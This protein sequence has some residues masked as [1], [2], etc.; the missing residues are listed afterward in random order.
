MV[1]YRSTTAKWAGFKQSDYFAARWSGVMFIR[2]KGNYMFALKSDDGSKLY[3]NKKLTVNNDGLHGMRSQSTRVNLRRSYLPIIVEFFEKTGG[4]GIE[5]TFMGPQTS[6]KMKNVGA[7]E[8]A[9]NYF[10]VRTPESPKKKPA[11][12]KAAAKPAAR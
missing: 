12:K 10:K 7:S 8:M 1:N 6:N 3:M 11:K 9:A 2:Q 5:F 4:A